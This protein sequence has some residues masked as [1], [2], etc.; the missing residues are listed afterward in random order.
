M[1]VKGIVEKVFFVFALAALSG[2]L[3]TETGNPPLTGE[4]S[5]DAHSSDPATAALRS[6][7]GGIT[8]DGVWLGTGE[9]RF[10]DVALCA[11]APAGVANVAPLDVDNHANVGAAREALLYDTAPYCRVRVPLV[12]QDGALPMGAPASLAGNTLVLTGTSTA[13]VPYELVSGAATDLDL[14][15][16]GG[17]FVLAEGEGFVFLG[18]DVGTWF[19]GVDLDS[20]TPNGDG[21]IIVSAEENTALLTTFE[22]NLEAGFELYRDLDRDGVPDEPEPIAR[23]VP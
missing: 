4:I 21:T 14:E 20:G 7:E 3:G 1:N 8:V 19:T 22:S 11:E 6:S 16:T 15:A 17:Q 10:V 12:R 5:V 23:G 9:M 13:G 2:C 18:F